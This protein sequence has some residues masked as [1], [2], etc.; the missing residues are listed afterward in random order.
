M[1]LQ[2]LFKCNTSNLRVIGNF[3]IYIATLFHLIIELW[4]VAISKRKK[5]A[6][7]IVI[8][9]V[10]WN[11]YILHMHTFFFYYSWFLISL[12]YRLC[13]TVNIQ[14]PRLERELNLFIPTICSR[15]WTKSRTVLVAV[16][17]ICQSC[18]FLTLEICVWLSL[19]W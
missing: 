4:G 9:S 7:R 5:N 6:Y 19:L 15:D 14:W 16:F 11:N 13:W 10:S 1:Q 3:N 2:Q 17:V 18:L 8:W 12:F